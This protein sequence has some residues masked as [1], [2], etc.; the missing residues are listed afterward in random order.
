VDA[1]TVRPSCH[2]TLPCRHG[3]HRAD[4]LSPPGGFPIV[5]GALVFDI[6]SQH[7][8]HIERQEV[9]LVRLPLPP[10]FTEAVKKVL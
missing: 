8:G 7:G 1:P 5:S 6:V 2:R 4:D 3:Y 9:T 10:C